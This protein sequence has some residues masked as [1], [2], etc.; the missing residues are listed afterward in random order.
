MIT[1]HHIVL[2]SAVTL[3]PTAH[4]RKHPSGPKR[5][6]IPAIINALVAGCLLVVARQAALCDDVLPVD[7]VLR[8]PGVRMVAVEFF[9][10][11]CEPCKRAV[12]RWEEIRRKYRKDGLRLIVVVTRDPGGQCANPGWTPDKIICDA[13]GR[14]ADLWGVSALPAAFL[15]NWQGT[16][17]VGRGDVESV[18]QAIGTWVANAPRAFLEVDIGSTISK[19]KVPSLNVLVSSAVMKGGK[20]EVA[21]SETDRALIRSKA[22]QVLRD[23]SYDQTNCRIGGELPPNMLMR[24]GVADG[25]FYVKLLSMETGCLVDSAVVPWDANDLGACVVS[26]VS[27]LLANLHRSV[28]PDMGAATIVGLNSKS[29]ARLGAKSDSLDVWGGEE[30]TGRQCADLLSKRGPTQGRAAAICA[31]KAVDQ[32]LEAYGRLVIEG[33]GKDMADHLTRKAEEHRRIELLY[34]DVV[35][36]KEPYVSVAALYRIG[37]MYSDFAVAMRAAPV[38]PEFRDDPEL[39]EEFKIQLSEKAGV[40]ER[41]AQLAYREAAAEVKLGNVRGE[42]PDRV[43]LALREGLTP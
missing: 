5:G 36:R 10:S 35:R 16:Q 26:G 27:K 24:A 28:T 6:H 23:P 11:W 38:P 31:F 34:R 8:Q 14:L 20:L 15:W 17:L 13:D 18:D 2:A 25:Y 9:A 1:R 19:A 7:E 40:L 29:G 39:F 22:A 41:K 30:P 43:R 12:P 21:A 37:Q 33:S 32:E 3:L 42:W 4:V